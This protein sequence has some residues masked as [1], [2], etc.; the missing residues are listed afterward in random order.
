MITYY[1][2][3]G[4]LE[5]E[6]RGN[7]KQ[8]VIYKEKQAHDLSIKEFCVWSFLAWNFQTYDK[9][10]Q[11]YQKRCQE[12][13]MPDNQTF[14][15]V[16]SRLAERGLIASGM[17]YTAADAMYELISTLR[18]HPLQISLFGRIMATGYLLFRHGISFRTLIK[19]VR[20]Y[21]ANELQKNIL[22]L[23][24]HIDL[25]S[26]ELITC[27]EKGA[28]NIPSEDQLIDTA[29]QGEFTYENL[30]NDTR[31]SSLKHPIMQAVVD[32]YLNKQIIFE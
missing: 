7:R 20:Q 28:V 2:A 32:L 9:L 8:P 13:T 16:L 26:A 19:N 29:Y 12:L 22:N 23:S 5:I 1:T 21:P 14:N 6:R 25:S 3:I 18:I 31:F 4:K 17:G 11:Q 15:E 10:H 27:I 24:G 30:H